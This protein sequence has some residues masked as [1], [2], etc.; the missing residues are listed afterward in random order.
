MHRSLAAWLTAEVWRASLATAACAFLS[1]L[2][3]SPL[4]IV[5]GAIPAL[6][7]L[8][9]GPR[10][11]AVVAL[12]ASAA[13]VARFGAAEQ[14]WGLALGFA[15]AEC[16]AP[17]ALAVVLRS[18]RSLNFSFQLAVLAAGVCLGSLHV[19]LDDPMGT[20][21]KLVRQAVGILQSAG[22]T[23]NEQE[24]LSSFAATNW[25]TYVSLWLLGVCGSLFLAR[26]WQA[27]LTAPGAFGEEF[28]SL[29]VGKSLGAMCTILIA[30]AIGLQFA[31]VA[32]SALLAFVWLALTALGLQG[33]ASLHSLKASGRIGRSWLIVTYVALV[34][35]NIVAVVA[36][37]G[38]GLA[39][40]WRRSRLSG[41]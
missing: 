30:L 36:L 8:V 6:M 2:G 34:V 1:P 33:L 16:W 40:N 29:S 23:L 24:L 25:G 26:W 21:Q 32:A 20:W 35:F 39:D 14:H 3:L 5:A 38:W 4:A 19:L 7:A 27:L 9:S 12:V 31:G 18:T 41:A 15:I 22:W 10:K 17:W 11:G 28:R 37:A 13:L